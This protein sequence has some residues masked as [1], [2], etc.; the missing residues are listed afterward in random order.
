LS[1]KKKVLILNPYP[2]NQEQQ[3]KSWAWPL[4]NVWNN[5]VCQ[6]NL[7]TTHLKDVCHVCSVIYVL[8]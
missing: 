4:N 7:R 1:E 2:V 6:K 5:E 8:L 3:K